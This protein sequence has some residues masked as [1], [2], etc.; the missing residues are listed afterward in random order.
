[1]I[2]GGEQI[3]KVVGRGSQGSSKILIVFFFPPLSASQY[4]A[5]SYLQ[6]CF[7]KLEM[8]WVLA[9]PEKNLNLGCILPS[10]L[11]AVKRKL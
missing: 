7:S 2:L 8:A 6:E 11:Y 4:A 3:R 5:L 9:V 1:M 10:K